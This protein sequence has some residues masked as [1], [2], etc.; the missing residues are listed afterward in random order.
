MKKHLSIFILALLAAQV[1]IAQHATRKN[2]NFPKVGTYQTLVCDFHMHTVFSDGAVWPTERILEAYNEGLDGVAITDHIEIQRHTKDIPTSLDLNRSHELSVDIANK[3]GIINIKGTEIT[4]QVMPGHSNAI[5]I[6]DANA[7]RNPSNNKNIMSAEG[8]EQAVRIAKSQGG[9][10]FYNHP[11]HQ[12]ADDKITLPP[13]VE[14]VIKSGDLQGIEV[15]NGD[16]FSRQGYDW[17]MGSNLTLIANSDAH[18][19]MPLSMNQHDIKH[20]AATLVFAKERSEQGIKEALQ[21]QRTLI[22]WREYVIG[23]K[24]LLT[25]FVMACCPVVDYSFDGKQLSFRTTNLSPQKFTLEPISTDSFFIAHPLVLV[26]G[27]ETLTS[28]GVKGEALEN[29][30]IQ[31]RVINAWTDYQEPLIVS[32]SFKKK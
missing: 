22:W 13:Q 17:A 11:F 21:N 24:E 7:M 2:L 18:S 5:F 31:F 3:M 25:Q 15:V 12:L 1:S 30:T 27:T 16:R 10:V 32:Y 19:S 14:T 23:R 26:P 9:F 4:R 29:F 8:Y 6:T 28:V 20:R